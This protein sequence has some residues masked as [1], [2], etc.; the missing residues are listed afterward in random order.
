MQLSRWCHLLHQDGVSA[1][2]NSLTL[3]VVYVPTEE[4]HALLKKLG[5]Q[6]DV[7]EIEL[8]QLL[9]SQG[10]LVEN[11]AADERT[12]TEMREQL[13]SEMSLEL[14]NCYTYLS[15]MVVICGVPTALK[16]HRRLWV[17]SDQRK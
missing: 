15:P 8:A 2:V 4:L 10:L 6:N 9:A 3:G 1:L 5:S 12:F 7:G 16:K 17:H 11:Q 14:S 13:K